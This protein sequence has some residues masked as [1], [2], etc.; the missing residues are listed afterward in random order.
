[1]VFLHNSKFENSKFESP[2]SPDNQINE[3]MS[4]GK[5]LACFNIALAFLSKLKNV[6]FIDF[7]SSLCEGKTMTGGDHGLP[8]NK[9]FAVQEKK[10]GN[11]LNYL[12]EIF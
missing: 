2:V 11:I 1:M 5:L 10:D 6:K 8:L 4:L 7:R 3:V 9:C 12:Q